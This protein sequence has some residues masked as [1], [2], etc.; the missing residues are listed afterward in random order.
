VTS[1]RLWL[2]PTQA[3][4]LV[5]STRGVSLGAAVPILRDA[6]ESGEVRVCSV[7]GAAREYLPDDLWS[8]AQFDLERN[9]VTADD[10][11]ALARGLNERRQYE[12]LE[13]S[14]DDLR[15][16]LRQHRE[17]LRQE[18][19]IAP[20]A[21][22]APK[23]T[24]RRPSRRKPFWPDARKAALEWFDENGFPTAGDGG[25]KKLEDHIADWVT[26]HG[27]HAAESTIRVYVKRWIGEYK[28]SVSAAE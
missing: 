3:A 27:H 26:T 9:I 1:R 23:Q 2:R 20:R 12:A 4:Q 6:M 18:Y 7:A 16:W 28:A 22:P 25:Q 13:I 24:N 5:K 8:S 21:S 11:W 10:Q 15:D 14:A 17:H 19:A